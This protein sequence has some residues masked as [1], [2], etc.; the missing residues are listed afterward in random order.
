MRGSFSTI[1]A[2]DF[3]I[4]IICLGGCVL[5]AVVYAVWWICHQLA[6]QSNYREKYGDGWEAEFERYHGSL[7]QVQF[8]I[9]IAVCCL[10]GFVTV[11]AWLLRQA[12]PRKRTK[13]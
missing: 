10:L 7:S 2:G 1:L 11:S 5:A 6:L 8:R 4:R 3:L 13:R 9:A 12:F